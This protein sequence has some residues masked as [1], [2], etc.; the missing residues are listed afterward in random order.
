MYQAEVETSKRK[1]WNNSQLSMKQATNQDEGNELRVHHN[2]LT[3]MY[4]KDGIPVCVEDSVLEV[5]WS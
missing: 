4:A 2:G 3:R 5:Q 1:R